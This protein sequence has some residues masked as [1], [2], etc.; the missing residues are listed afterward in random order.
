MPVS[1][2]LGMGA[3]YN[4]R[5]MSESEML[6]LRKSLRAFGAVQPVI[7]NSRTNTIVGGHQR[8]RA[9]QLEGMSEFPVKLVD[10]DEFQEQALNLALNRIHGEWDMDLLGPILAGLRDADTDM[11]LTGFEESEIDRILAEMGA[12]RVGLTEPDEVPSIP[13]TP[14][15]VHGELILLGEHRLLCGDSTSGPMVARLF[16][17]TLADA[18]WTDPPYGV[19]YEGKTKEKLTIENDGGAGLR[20]LLLGAFAGA[21]RHLKPGAPIYVS[22]TAGTKSMEFMQAFIET[23][24]SWRQTLVWVKDSFVLGH[25]DYH[26]RHEPILYGYKPGAG[27]LGRGGPGWHGDDKQDTVIDVPRPKAS[28]EHPTMKPVELIE[29]CLSNSTQAG[30]TVFDPFLGSGS[31]LMACEKTGRRCVGMELAP[32]YVDVIVERWENFTGKRA[33]RLGTD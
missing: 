19:D 15:T 8:V 32:Q 22:S 11:G 28:R 2:L 5:V 1:E 4:P 13:E 30:E 9:A 29:R 16:G 20:M 33:T 31:T 18:M 12:T 23:G 7:V 25:S 17:A 26:Y 10:L 21:D 6:S 3:S 24:W 14:L 27:R